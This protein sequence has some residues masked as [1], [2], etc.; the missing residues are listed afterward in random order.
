MNTTTVHL[1]TPPINLPFTKADIIFAM[2]M[3]EHFFPRD[4][5]TQLNFL[6]SVGMNLAMCA[7]TAESNP[8]IVENCAL[9]TI[10]GWQELVAHM[11]AELKEANHATKN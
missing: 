1:G 3:C 8:T 4:L 10:N 11:K 9:E 2:N 7:A 5:A 6:S